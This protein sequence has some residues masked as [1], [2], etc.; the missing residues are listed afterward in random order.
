[1]LAED[2]S[3]EDRDVEASG[4]LAAAL[5]PSVIDAL[6]ADAQATGTPIDG[7]DGLLNRMTKAVIERALAAEMT[8]ELGYE[9][10]NPAGAGSGNSRNGYTAIMSASGSTRIMRSTVTSWITGPRWRSR[11]KRL[12]SQAASSLR[13]VR[14]WPD[15]CRRDWRTL[16]RVA[17]LIQVLAEGRDIAAAQLAALASDY[18][19]PWELR[20]TLRGFE[21]RLVDF[22]EQ[23]SASE[24]LMG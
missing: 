12:A 7:V 14:N 11:S 4:R 10:G 20:S 8:L 18:E 3:V 15:Q 13:A 1:L 22:N 17:E 2:T 5:D 19:T 24:A 9:R 21:K 23:S 16:R 6:L